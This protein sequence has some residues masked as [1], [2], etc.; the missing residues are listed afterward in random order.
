MNTTI[1][2]F[3]FLVDLKFKI[4]VRSTKCLDKVLATKEIVLL[5]WKFGAAVT[6]IPALKGEQYYSPLFS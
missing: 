5:K 4:G 2:A 3:S 1:I 6:I